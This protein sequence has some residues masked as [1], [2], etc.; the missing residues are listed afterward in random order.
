MHKWRVLIFIII[1]LA[2]LVLALTLD[3]FWIIGSTSLGTELTWK[4]I[5][6]SL[7]ST[8][9]SICGV[10]VAWELLCKQS[11]I[12]EFLQLNKMSESCIDGGIKA[13]FNNFNDIDWAS[14]IKATKSLVVFFAYGYTWRNRMRESLQELIARGGSLKIILPDFNC[15]EVVDELDR[16]F[17]YGKYSPQQDPLQSTKERIKEAYQDFKTMGAIVQFHN[18]SI[19]SLY[20]CMDSECIYVPFK[21]CQNQIVYPSIRLS[22]NG[23]FR[24]YIM[25]DLANI[26]I[27]DI[28]QSEQHALSLPST[29]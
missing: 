5:S 9:A 10:S 19:H 22:N 6:I 24:E 26:E 27:Y 28:S 2:S 4:T 17:G 23:Q 14:E 20:F 11:F 15:A 8:I 18:R 7:L 13:Y 21:N 12:R 16:R 3:S 25:S 1:F 29:K